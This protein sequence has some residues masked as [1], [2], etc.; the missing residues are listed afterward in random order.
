MSSQLP[1][2]AGHTDYRVEDSREI[3][4]AEEPVASGQYDPDSL[5]THVTET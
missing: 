2:L 5:R 1:T 3:L 4:D